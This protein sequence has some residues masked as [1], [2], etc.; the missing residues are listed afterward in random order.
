MSDI[1]K[2]MPVLFCQ[3]IDFFDKIEELYIGQVLIVSR[4]SKEKHDFINEVWI[5]VGNTTYRKLDES[6]ISNMNGD[7]N[8]VII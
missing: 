6:N 2:I 8:S 1:Q 7:E 3:A 5:R 4:Y